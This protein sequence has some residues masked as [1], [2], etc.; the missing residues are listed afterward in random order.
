MWAVVK[1][2]R[3]SHFIFHIS[4]HDNRP[5]FDIEGITLWVS[6]ILNIDTRC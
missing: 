1:E 2:I 5:L 3:F 6:Y 4:M